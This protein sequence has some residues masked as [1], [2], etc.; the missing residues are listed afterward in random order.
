M[1]SSLGNHHNLYDIT[2]KFKCIQYDNN[3]LSSTTQR[4]RRAMRATAKPNYIPSLDIEKCIV[5]LGVCNGSN[6]TIFDYYNK[7]NQS[8]PGVYHIYENNS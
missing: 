2:Y 1:T 3:M 4:R 5:D 8:S 6:R 7:P